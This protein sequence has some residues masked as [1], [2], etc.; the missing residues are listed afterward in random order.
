MD[1]LDVLS[2][3]KDI[4]IITGPTAGG[5][6]DIAQLLSIEMNGEIISA[7][8]RVIY[9]D[10]KIGTGAY[11][12]DDS[13]E[14]HMVGFL[15]LNERY[16]L[17]DYLTEL[18]NIVDDIRSRGK[19]IIIC[20]GT[21]LYIERLIKGIDGLPPPDHKLRKELES[22]RINEGNSQLHSLL[23]K[24]DP[25]LGNEVHPNNLKRIIRSIEIARGNDTKE[26]IKPLTGVK[27]VYFLYRNIEDISKRIMERVDHM[28]LNGWVEEVE[29][30]IDQGATGD[31][32]AFE[33]L[34]YDQI[35]SYIEGK[36]SLDD[37]RNRVFDSHLRL[38]KS[39]MKWINR[40]P[41]VKL[42][43]TELQPFEVVDII[44]S[45]A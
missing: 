40:I 19:C 28:L 42:D 37:V 24:M 26:P 1:A 8:S 31:E 21:M 27:G 29:Y 25:E 23:K 18:N 43:I 32:P 15:E 4:Y 14:T 38:F 2:E 11:T 7:D 22:L 9:K 6:T 12:I 13:T 10:L 45:K 5:K 33:S 44:R 3:N 17:Y 16:R 41:S 36:S 35:L 34:G 20:G 30:L 39:Q